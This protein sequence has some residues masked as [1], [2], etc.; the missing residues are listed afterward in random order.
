[1]ADPVPDRLRVLVTNDDG[2]ASPGLL[3]LASAVA[4]LG[5]EVL[6]VAPLADRSGVGSALGWS[7]GQSV[8]TER[9]TVP[10]LPGIPFHG[11]AG[12]PAL[13]VTLARTG[14]FGRPPWCVVAGINHGA[15]TGRSVLHSGTVC[16]ALTAATQ[17]M[18]GLAVSV[19]ARQPVHLASAARVAAEAARWLVAA[20]KRTVLNVNVP[21][22][23]FEQL[24]GV[25]WGR[26]A[27]Y[28]RARW[29]SSPVDGGDPMLALAVSDI[30]PD[31]GTDEGLVAAGYVSVTPLSGLQALADETAVTALGQA[32]G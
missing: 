32:L 25:R 13:A 5:H 20:R 11:V 2:V 17:G 24:R 6:V 3:A 28:G 23:P 1:M 16:A 31:P 18:S 26:L 22:L 9:L 7:S 19:D 12:T 30:P 27:A 10:E 29:T 15:N 14:V 4:T 8:R 21:D